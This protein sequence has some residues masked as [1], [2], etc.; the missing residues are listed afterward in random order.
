MLYSIRRFFASLFRAS[1][2]RGFGIQSPFAYGFV[3]GV[4]RDKSKHTSYEKLS[5]E[6]CH[7]PGERRLQKFYCRLL[8][9]LNE[10]YSVD[11]LYVIEGIHASRDSYKTWCDIVKS[12]KVGVS[13]DLFDCGVLFFDKKMDKRNYKVMLR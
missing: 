4:V 10:D 5:L 9:F 12:D 6:S 2:S 7:S 8:E 13:F 11:A 1:S 3:T